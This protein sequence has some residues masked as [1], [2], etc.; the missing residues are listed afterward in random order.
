[1]ARLYNIYR[2]KNPSKFGGFFL[3]FYFCGLNH[4]NYYHETH[5]IIA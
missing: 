4:F 3:F 1:M 5:Y 2:K